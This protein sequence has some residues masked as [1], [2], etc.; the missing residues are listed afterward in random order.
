MGLTWN[1]INFKDSVLIV[2]KQWK[3]INSNPKKFGFDEL[4]SKNS[5]RTF[6]I[7]PKTLKYL[8]N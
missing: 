8:K 7:P 2:N 3:V 4:K 5:Y 1:D 6:P